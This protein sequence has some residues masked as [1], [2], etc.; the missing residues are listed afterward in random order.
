MHID[1]T[2]LVESRDGDIPPMLDS[3]STTVVVKH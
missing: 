1:E 3:L 2:Q